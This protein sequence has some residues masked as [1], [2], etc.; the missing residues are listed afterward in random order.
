MDYGT[1]NLGYR[2]CC[3]YVLVEI[4]ILDAGCVYTILSAMVPISSAMVKIL[5]TS[6][7]LLSV[8]ITP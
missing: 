7:S 3:G 2:D 6:P 8:W 4:D 1:D 5:L